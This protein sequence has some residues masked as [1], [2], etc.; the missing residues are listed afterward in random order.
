MVRKK[1][2]GRKKKGGDRD[3]ERERETGLYD[4][5]VKYQGACQSVTHAPQGLVMQGF[6]LPSHS[7]LFSGTDHWAG[8]CQ[9]FIFISPLLTVKT[10]RRSVC[11]G[12]AKCFH[13]KYLGAK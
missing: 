7:C 8:V 3:R 4:V 11:H 5:E 9:I 12:K 2:G 13:L 10:A 1:E 6:L